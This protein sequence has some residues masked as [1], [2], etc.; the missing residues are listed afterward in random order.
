MTESLLEYLKL[1][2]V[3]GGRRDHAVERSEAVLIAD[4]LAVQFK[5]GPSHLSV[6]IQSHH[7]LQTDRDSGITRL[8]RYRQRDRQGVEGWPTLYMPAHM[9]W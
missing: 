2:V 3:H 8:R 1:N 9:F 4:L 7:G 5:L 6:H